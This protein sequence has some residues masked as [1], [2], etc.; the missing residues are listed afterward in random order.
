MCGKAG[1]EGAGSIQA[2]RKHAVLLSAKTGRLS[3]ETGRYIRETGHTHYSSYGGMSKGRRGTEGTR[4]TR[5]GRQVN[6]EASENVEGRGERSGGTRG[7][8]T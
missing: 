6:N 2:I 1:R 4:K 5:G 3:M 7:T 8:E